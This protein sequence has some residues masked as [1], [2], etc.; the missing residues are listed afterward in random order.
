MF[1]SFRNN[2]L[3]NRN[4]SSSPSGDDSSFVHIMDTSEDT[5][6]RIDDN[7]VPSL[8]LSVTPRHDVIGI[9]V[10]KKSTQFCATVTARDLP[11]D[12]TSRAPVD[13]IVCLDV[14][15]SMDGSKLDLCKT[16]LELLIRELSSSDRFGLVTF[17]SDVALEIPVRMLSNKNKDIALKKIKKL[18][19]RG[20][21]NMSGG[22]AMAAQQIKSIDS[23]HK[24][25]TVFLLTD[26]QANQGISDR[27]GIV[28]LTK[29]CLVS[30]N[31][32]NIPIHCFGYGNDHDRE[33]LRDIASA[34]EGGTY[35][36][37]GNDS[38]V[39]SAFGDALGGVL[40]VVAQNT[41]ISLMVPTSSSEMGSSILNVYHDRATK[42]P[43][44]S[45]SIALN[46]F[47]AE[48]SRDVVF[49]VALSRHSSPTPI[50]HVA[51]KMSY[52]DTINIK[53]IQSD[54][55]EGSV[56]RPHGD[57]LSTDNLNVTLQCTRINTTTAIKEAEKL[58]E[59]GKFDDA[60]KKL[61][62][63]IGQL[64]KDSELF[65]RSNPF[66][67][68]MLDEL[69]SI[70]S[71][72]SSRTTYDNFGSKYMQSRLMTHTSQRCSEDCEE[73]ANAYRSTGKL[74]R[75]KKMKTASKISK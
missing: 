32:N 27:A 40:S 6:V 44:G 23:P 41:M 7:N 52:L 74:L 10:D 59:L 12:D 11:Q 29:N 35:Y 56:T 72:L 14:S 26:G 71:G 24:V 42:N 21:T 2:A 75:A 64:E 66:I 18:T 69:N 43:D 39:S 38:N 31:E 62:S 49:E 63:Y 61:N 67:V 33:M 48:E 45:Y 57:T 73:T 8:R 68:Q 34:T 16:T 70:V 37:V 13:I 25:Q 60:K 19:T 53:Q 58:A 5:F 46:D 54:Y 47:Y 9:D 20:C 4:D 30:N 17:G 15:G 22:I 36:Y 65:D 50:P 51:A 3:K 1:K 28:K 55:V